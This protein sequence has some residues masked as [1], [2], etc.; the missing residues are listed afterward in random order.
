MSEHTK[1]KSQEKVRLTLDLSTNMNDY[2]E[3]MSRKTGKTKSELLRLAVD[4]L[5]RAQ[6]AK[7]EDMLVGA[8][9]D[10]PKARVRVEREFVGI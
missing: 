4:F 10:D 2:L 3:D 7:E 6:R 5:V 1:E 9:K 8:W